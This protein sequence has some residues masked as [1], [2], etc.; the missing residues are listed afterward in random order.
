VKNSDELIPSLP[1]IIIL[2]A[3]CYIILNLIF[4]TGKLMQARFPLSF[5]SLPF[6]SPP[7]RSPLLLFEVDPLN[8]ARGSGVA[9]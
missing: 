1:V 6:P 5:S 3:R 2:I 4:K 8:P 7:F 9:L